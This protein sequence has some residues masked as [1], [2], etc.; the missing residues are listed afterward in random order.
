MGRF[1][2]HLRSGEE[3]I[4]DHDGA[5]FPDLPAARRE[6]VLSARQIL[7]DAIMSGREDVPELFVIADGLGHTLDTLPLAV[8]L[9]RRLGG[10]GTKSTP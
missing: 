9:P 3:V 6:A 2:F 1:Y 4:A 7:S 10:G 5:D 8:V